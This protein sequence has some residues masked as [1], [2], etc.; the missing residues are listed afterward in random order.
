MQKDSKAEMPTADRLARIATRISPG[1]DYRLRMLVLIERR[2]L[3]RIL[4][5]LLDQALP[6]ATELLEQIRDGGPAPTEQVA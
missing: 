2:P 4:T 5:E 1:V 6:P 3:S